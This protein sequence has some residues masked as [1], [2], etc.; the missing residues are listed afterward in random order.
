MRRGKSDCCTCEKQKA[1]KK[2]AATAYKDVFYNNDFDYLSD[3]CYNDWHLGEH[4][5]RMCCRRWG[6][7]ST[8]ADSTDCDSMTERSIRNNGEG[9]ELVGLDRRGPTIPPAPDSAVRQR[10]AW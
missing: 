8:S 6:R 2:A 10:P 7:L 5:K 3:P 1:L 4:L 9:P